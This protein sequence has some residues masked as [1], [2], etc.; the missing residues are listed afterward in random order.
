MSVV[1][2]LTEQPR[3]R[4]SNLPL[5]AAIV[6]V[7]VNLRPAVSGVSALL[8]QLQSN[9]DLSTVEVALLGSLPTIGLALFAFPGPWLYRRWSEERLVVTSMAIILA[10]DVVRLADNTVSLF[11]GTVLIALGTGVI[12]GVIPGIV[13]RAYPEHVPFVMA[14]YAAVLTLGAAGGAAFASTGA[15][16]FNWAP[17]TTLA[18]VTVPLA[19]LGVLGWTI[20][21]RQSAARRQISQAVTEVRVWR[22]PMSWWLSAYFAGIAFVFYVLLSWVP[23]IAHGRGLDWAS[24]GLVLST[25]SLAQIGGSLLLPIL[26]GQW[27]DQRRLTVLITATALVGLGAFGFGSFPDGIWF[28]AV[29]LGLGLGAAFGLAMTLIGLRVRD[30]KVAIRLSAMTQGL[31]YSVSATGPFVAGLLHDITESWFLP[32]LLMMVIC[33]ALAA[34]GQRAGRNVTVGSCVEAHRT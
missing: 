30:E 6:L 27:P 26:M 7:T 34:V 16:R 24:S 12:T 8:E 17:T 11:T 33:V 14:I 25:M 4:I 18:V 2:T 5:L 23:T 9:L 20:L 19:V 29:V 3:G 22:E 13:K 21:V 15:S 10:G 31:G 28:G 1:Q 32:I